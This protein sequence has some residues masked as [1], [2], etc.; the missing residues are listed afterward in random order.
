VAA[1]FI[2]WHRAA[3]H[4]LLLGVVCGLLGA[5]L[6]DWLAGA[7]ILAAYTAHTLADQLGFMGSNLW[8][9]FRSR[10][11]EGLKR[12][13]SGDA[14]W[15]FGIVWVACLL[16]FWSLYRQ[17]PGRIPGLNLLNFFFYG[18]VLPG[19]LALLLRRR[20]RRRAPKGT[21]R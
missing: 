20:L 12:A 18:A 10:R 9:P 6:W 7:V 19:V 5:L 16:I 4:S 21:A 14:E 3:S 1:R 17:T 11:T 15:N 8:F 2:P 13:H